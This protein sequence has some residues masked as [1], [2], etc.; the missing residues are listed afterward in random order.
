MKKL[1]DDKRKTI[2]VNI[3]G[4]R[5]NIRPEMKR[6]LDYLET[7]NPSDNFTKNLQSKVENLRRDHEWR[8]NYMTLEMKMDLKYEEGKAEGLAEGKNQAKLELIHK[9]Q[10]KGKSIEEIAEEIEESVE[11]VEKLL[12]ETV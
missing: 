7:G 12:A 9:K 11:Y 1:I 5:R 4:D 6:L 8:E 10:A 3:L 2:F